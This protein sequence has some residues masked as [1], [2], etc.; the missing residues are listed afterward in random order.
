MRSTFLLRRLRASSASFVADTHF[1]T[2]QQQQ[3]T[4]L[5]IPLHVL[6]DILDHHFKVLIRSRHHCCKQI[7]DSTISQVLTPFFLT[8]TYNTQDILDSN[9]FSGP[10]DFS[11]QQK[12]LDGNKPLKLQTYLDSMSLYISTYFTDFN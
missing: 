6:C 5:K 4:G 11:Y 2:N 1:N 8:L 3:Q 9:V 12:P 10:L 7:F